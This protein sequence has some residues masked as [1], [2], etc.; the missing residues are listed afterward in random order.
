M[1]DLTIVTE[2]S[3]KPLREVAHQICSLSL[4]FSLNS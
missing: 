3:P 4:A 1:G 2:S